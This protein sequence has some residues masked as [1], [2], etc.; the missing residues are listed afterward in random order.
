MAIIF[1]VAAHYRD[2]LARH[3]SWMF[4]GAETKFAENRRFFAE[5]LISPH[6][7]GRAVDLGAGPGFQS[8]P[9]AEAGFDVTAIDLSAELLDELARHN[10]DNLKV[11]TVVAD[12]CD[13]PSHVSAAVELVVCMG[14]TLTHLG[15]PEQLEQ[16][17]ENVHSLLEP[18]GRFVVTY[19]DLTSLPAG[20]DRFI[21]VRSDEQ[22]I[23]TCFLEDLGSHVAVHDL[24]YTREAD[25]WALHKS[26]YKK[27]KISPDGAATTLEKLGFAVEYRS[28]ARGL[29]TLIA[30]KHSKD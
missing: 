7:S 8:I 11:R 24:I 12:L 25:G 23:F 15:S 19:R 13:F 18:G 17:F 29:V 20:L 6:L 10:K 30:R 2:L 4:G 27:L 3:Y 21:P 28:A 16:L 9:L 22:A 5:H 1:D 26:A 14:D